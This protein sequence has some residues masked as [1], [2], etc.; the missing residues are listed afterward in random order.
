MSLTFLPI[1]LFFYKTNFDKTQVIWIGTKKYSTHSIKTRWK[2]SWGTSQFKLLGITYD[3]D[4]T[5]IISINYG[6][7][8]QTLNKSIKLWQRRALSPLGKLTVIKSLLLPKITHLL[9]ALPKPEITLLQE[10]NTLF[11]DFRWGR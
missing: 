7:K 10:I 1:P 9:I 8:I 4:L 5:K 3:V 6:N 2:L 11:Y